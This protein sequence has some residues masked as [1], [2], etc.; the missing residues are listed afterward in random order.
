[1]LSDNEVKRH[2]KFQTLFRVACFISASWV[3]GMQLHAVLGSS[4]MIGGLVGFGLSA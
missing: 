4:L 2:E 3:V 1:M